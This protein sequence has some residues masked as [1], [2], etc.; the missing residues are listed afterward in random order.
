MI[1]T[2]RRGRSIARFDVGSGVAHVTHGAQVQERRAGG[3]AHVGGKLLG[4]VVDRRRVGAVGLR[5]AQPGRWANEASIQP[6]GVGTLIP[7]P[8]SSHT[9]SSGIGRPWCGV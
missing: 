6:A 1:V 3:V 4:G 5:V 2:D 8:L 7:K 9:N